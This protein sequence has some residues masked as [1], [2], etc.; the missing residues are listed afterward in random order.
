MN[1]NPE[2]NFRY[3]FIPSVALGSGVDIIMFD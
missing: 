3:T 1:E 2:V